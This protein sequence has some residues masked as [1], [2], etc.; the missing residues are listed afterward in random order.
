MF[1][2]G[3]LSRSNVRIGIRLK[4]IYITGEG[5]LNMSLMNEK[6][7]WE[8]FGKH[9]KNK[10]VVLGPHTSFQLNNSPKRILFSLSHYK[11]ASRMIGDNKEILE[12][13]C[14]DGMGVHILAENAKK[15]VGVDFDKE[16]IDFA[17]KNMSK[18]NLEFV[19]EDFLNK[20]YGKFD[21]VVSND[22]IEHLLPENE[23]I[24]LETIVNNLKSTGIAIIGTPNEESQKYSSKIVRDAHINVYTADRLKTLL[25]GY[26]NNTFLFSGNDEMIHTGFYPLAHYFIVVG[27][28]MK[29]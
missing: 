23:N 12:L 14:N 27:C 9:Q 6:E 26:F 11:F 3:I 4:N 22:V 25:E 20:E 24:F 15:I 29:R 17:K 2:G 5:V 8:K 10:S 16:A 21:A 7:T 18:E 13:G 28:Y 19:C 1:L